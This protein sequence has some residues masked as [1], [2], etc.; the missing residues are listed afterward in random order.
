MLTPRMLFFKSE[1]VHKRIPQSE[2]RG[3]CPV[4]TRGFFWC[5]RPHFLVEK[6]RIF[7]NLWCVRIYRG[8]ITKM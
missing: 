6:N 8:L 2:E 3:V 5:G 1:A 4:R 7:R